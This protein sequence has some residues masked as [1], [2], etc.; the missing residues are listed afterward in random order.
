[1]YRYVFI[2]AAVVMYFLI[3]LEIIN[4]LC[5]RLGAHTCP[6][7]KKYFECIDIT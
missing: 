4:F 1:M 5:Y 2:R 6:A 3:V 7:I